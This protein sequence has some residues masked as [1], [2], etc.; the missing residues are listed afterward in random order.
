MIP[1]GRL[2]GTL[3]PVPIVSI[4]TLLITHDN[5]CDNDNDNINDND[6]RA[7][8]TAQKRV[9]D[10]ENGT[11]HKQEVEIKRKRKAVRQFCVIFSLG[12]FFTLYLL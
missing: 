3:H 1:G 11:V 8:E 5:D 2:D 12:T 10:M 6:C 9:T 7:S 4:N